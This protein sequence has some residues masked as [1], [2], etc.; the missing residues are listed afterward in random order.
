MTPALVAGIGLLGGLGACA[1]FA[2]DRAVSARAGRSFP[3]GILAV[4][5]SGAFALGVLVGAAVCA[6]A[7]ALAGTGALGAF[8]TF[9]GWMHDTRRLAAAGAQRRAM[10]NVAGSLLVGLAAVALGRWVGRGL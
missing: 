1:R 7:L 3:W 6:D 4:N 9:S 8:T 5:L 10:L 2:L